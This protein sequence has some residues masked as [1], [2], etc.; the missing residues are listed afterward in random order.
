MPN[1]DD[2]VDFND[3]QNSSHTVLK[4]I[5]GS[6]LEELRRQSRLYHQTATK[7]TS[8]GRSQ[9][10]ATPIN[11]INK[12]EAAAL[13]L[14]DLITKLRDLPSHPNPSGLRERFV[15]GIRAFERK[16]QKA[17][18]SSEEVWI[19]RYVLCT[20]ID[21]FALNTPWG[22]QSG[23]GQRSLLVIFHKEVNG[24]IRFFQFLK[25]MKHNPRK[26]IALLELM[27][28]CLSFGFQGR[29][30]LEQHGQAKLDDVR[31]D[32]YQLIRKTRGE[33]DSALAAQW[34]GVTEPTKPLGGI[35]P[36]WVIAAIVG[37]MLLLIYTGFRFSLANQA[38]P[39]TERLTSINAT[40]L[41]IRMLKPSVYTRAPI[42]QNLAVPNNLGLSKFLVEE[43]AADLISLEENS[44]ASKITVRGDGL[45]KSGSA[46]INN[47]FLALLKRIGHVLAQ[48]QGNVLVTGHTD[49]IPIS[50][51]QFP[52]NW[53]LSQKRAES[54]VRILQDEI[55]VS[56]RLSADGRGDVEPLVANDTARSRAL[57]RR[58]EITL[59]WHST[60]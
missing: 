39:V 52:S 55:G 29:Y 50:T 47:N 49:N 56:E 21:E 53:H 23:W 4:P 9:T 34:K 48:Y 25:K 13:T 32:L 15:K 3:D 38:I 17:E 46:I 44:Y 28:I 60:Y 51:L 33:P 26:Y 1:P 20:V 45:F 57:N 16:A 18:V 31:D 22:Q 5:P 6:D 30:R 27:Y 10:L 37:S 8:R 54:V 41:P 59:F 19:A 42:N 58:V 40:S 43:I 35:V 14:L 7:H 2:P 36:Y 24:G 11:G 12:I